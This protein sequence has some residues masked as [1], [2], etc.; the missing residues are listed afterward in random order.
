MDGG[1]EFTVGLRE[2][3]ALEHAVTDADHRLCRRANMLLD[4][5]YEL[6][7]QGYVQDRLRG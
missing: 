3:L 4:R 7:R 5:E 1:T 2:E 6:C